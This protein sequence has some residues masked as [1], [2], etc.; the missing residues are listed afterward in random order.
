MPPN[1]LLPTSASAPYQRNLQK[2]EIRLAHIHNGKWQD[3]ISCDFK[4]TKIESHGTQSYS[5][6]SYV[7]GLSR[8]TE[9]IQIDGH[10]HDIS[11][12]LACAIRQ[13]RG[14]R[15][16]I[17]IWIDAL[18]IN[19][20]DIDER[21]SQVAMMRDI[22]ASAQHVIVFLGHG[23]YH[24]IP[25]NY[26][27]D[28]LLA[29]V[30]FS[31]DDRDDSL[32]TQF[33]NSWETMCRRTEWYSFCTICAIRALSNI[34][35]YRATIKCIA[36]GKASSRLKLFELVRRFTNSQ[37]WQRVWVIQE[38]TVT[39]QIFVQYG[40][41]KVPWEVLVSSA[42]T[43]DSLGWGRKDTGSELFL[44]IERE[45]AK[46]LPVLSKQISEIERLRMEWD[47]GK[48]TTLL[49]LLQDFSSR[50]ATDDRDKVFALLGL[51]RDIKT[52]LP[53]YSL[54]TVQVYRNTVINLI[55]HSGSLTA[56][57]GDMKRKNSG[58][59]PS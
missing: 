9:A 59:I 45:Y 8:A 35:R 49:S 39:S 58:G 52:I 30:Q 1:A 14:E 51:A 33:H 3:P 46:V 36:D 25:K 17:L 34:D 6:L 43:C 56:L 37:W 23:S 7:W 28:R 20:D 47:D 2:R 41:V 27:T 57:S 54:N 10:G 29:P 13:L 4:S 53:N 21:S 26:V 50:R 15:N 44:D 12:N 22:Y 38:A 55:K 32:I 48:A 5:A 31:N 18:C 11:I 42:N 16:S 24:R 40:N 19:Q